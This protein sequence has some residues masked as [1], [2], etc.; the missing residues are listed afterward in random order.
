MD[1]SRAL[2]ELLWML[3]AAPRTGVMMALLVV[4]A[5]SD[6]RNYR[7][8]NWL[9]VGG[10]AFALGHALLAPHPVGIGAAALGLLAGLLL[11]LPLYALHIM[12]GGDVKLIAMNGAFL[13]FPDM[14]GALLASLI[15]GG[16]A[17]LAYALSR[18]MLGAMF[19]N[20]GRML[21]SMALSAVAG[22]RPAADPA[23]FVSVG[24]L[25][26]GVSIAVGTTGWLVGTQLGYL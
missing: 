25:P 12:G 20:I 24:R 10:A 9:T 17:A 2:L 8:P 21:Q 1:E 15:V 18:R 6:L 14:L 26:F 11:T 22:G 23:G 13:G 5:V 4:A 16:V 3:V 7:I 19:S